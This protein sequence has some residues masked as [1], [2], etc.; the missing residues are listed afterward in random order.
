MITNVLLN[1]V[2]YLILL[3]NIVSKISLRNNKIKII[4]FDRSFFHLL[5]NEPIVLGPHNFACPFCSKIM[6]VKRDMQRHIR[7]HTGEK[8]FACTMCNYKCAVKCS[9]VSHIARNHC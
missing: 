6:K 7:T 1:A 8:P 4:K 5:Q 2:L 9:L 3:E